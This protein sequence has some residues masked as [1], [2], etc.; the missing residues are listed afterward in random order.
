MQFGTII[1]G[2]GCRL[3]YGDLTERGQRA[4]SFGCHHEVPSLRIE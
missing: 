1:A 2:D 3:C 4:S